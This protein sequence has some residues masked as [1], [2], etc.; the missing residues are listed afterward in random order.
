MRLRY[1]RTCALSSFYGAGVEN[2]QWSKRLLVV[3]V[4][5]VD[6]LRL[7]LRVDRSVVEAQATGIED[8]GLL[9]RECTE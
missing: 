6:F 2:L 4:G 5:A 7:A 1:V 3:D 8:R 9:R